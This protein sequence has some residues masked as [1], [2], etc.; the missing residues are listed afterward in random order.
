MVIT[1]IFKTILYIK[2]FIFMKLDDVQQ[3]LEKN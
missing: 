3:Y 2:V 1:E